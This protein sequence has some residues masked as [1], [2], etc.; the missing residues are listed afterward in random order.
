MA[1]Q[2]E[3]ARTRE[4]QECIRSCGNCYATCLATVQHCLTQGGPH[5][6]PQ[7][8]ALLLNCADICQASYNFMLRGSALHKQVCAV[9][10]K[11]CLLKKAK[12]QTACAAL[13][14]NF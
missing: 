11:V 3:M 5:A 10:A 14:G 6:D 4:L 8:I 12:V 13:L 9:C 2:T 1:S 7:H